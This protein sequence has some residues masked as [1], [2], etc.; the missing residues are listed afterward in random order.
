MLLRVYRWPFKRFPQPIGKVICQS[1]CS[2]SLPKLLS[3]SAPAAC[4]CAAGKEVFVGPAHKMCFIFALKTPLPMILVV[5]WGMLIV[6]KMLTDVCPFSPRA[7]VR[8]ALNLEA[9]ELVILGIFAWNGSLL[10][11]RAVSRGSSKAAAVRRRFRAQGCVGNP[12]WSIIAGRI[13]PRPG[14]LTPVPSTGSFPTASVKHQ[15]VW[16]ARIL[17]PGCIL[18]SDPFL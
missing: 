18:V 9:S 14:Y 17:T 15:T 1:P 8:V 6:E 16:A 13:K 4:R 10:E 11:G 7:A 3:C 5:I 12:G 2:C